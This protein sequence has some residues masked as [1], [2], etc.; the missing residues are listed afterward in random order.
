MHLVAH[1]AGHM[2]HEGESVFGGEGERGGKGGRCGHTSILGEHQ[3]GRQELA[4]HLK[5]SKGKKTY[6]EQCSAMV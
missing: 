1:G 4:K 2:I 6:S 5:Y 3:Q